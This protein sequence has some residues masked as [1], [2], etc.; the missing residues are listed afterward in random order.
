MKKSPLSFWGSA[1]LTPDRSASEKMAL[2]LRGLTRAEADALYVY[3]A[4]GYR[5]INSTLNEGNP[6]VLKSMEPVFQSLDGALAKLEKN[7]YRGEVSRTSG[8]WPAR[9]DAEHRVG[10][11][12]TYP[13]YTSTSMGNGGS[14]LAKV[15]VKYELTIKSLTG[16]KVQDFVM[17]HYE[18]EVL[19]PRG[20]KFKVISR[21]KVGAITRI[22]LEQIE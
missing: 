7:I 6:A 13:A 3:A 16:R 5:E 11:I 15:P 22:R 4:L 1:A 10:N 9:V 20:A 19:I 12:V 18:R 21:T 8:P 14:G 17:N 2:K